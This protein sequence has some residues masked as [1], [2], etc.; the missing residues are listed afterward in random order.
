MYELDQGKIGF[1]LKT[2]AACFLESDTG[3]RSRVF[4]D[5]GE[6]YKS[7]SEIVH[8]ARKKRASGEERKDTFRKGF[9]VARRSVVKLLRDGP[10][11]DWNE[12]VISVYSDAAAH[13]P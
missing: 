1:K 6:F 12:M 7:R 8:N 5:V 9:D 10:P 2:R 13:R 11:Q 3:A 4:K